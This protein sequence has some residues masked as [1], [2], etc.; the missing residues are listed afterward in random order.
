MALTIAD[1]C[2]L[3]AVAAYLLPITIVK[4][5][6]LKA[7]DNAR[8]RDPAFFADPFRSRG[9][10]AHLNGQEGFAFFA[11]AVILAQLRGA[12]QPRVDELAVAYVVLRLVFVAA[13]L[14]DK[15]KLRSPAWALGFAVN[16]ALLLSPL[17]ARG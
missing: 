6:S 10:G 8:P 13:Y 2:I 17:W 3:G 4:Y 15:P 11:A 7:F 12:A 1:L 14:A 16:V 9:L 5:S